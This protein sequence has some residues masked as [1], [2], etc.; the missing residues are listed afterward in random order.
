MTENGNHTTYLN[1]DFWGDG[2]WH[3][4]TLQKITGPRA[5]ESPNPHVV[6]LLDSLMSDAH[7]GAE[8]EGNKSQGFD[9]FR[10]FDCNIIVYIIYSIYIIYIA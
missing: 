9:Q 4:F 7:L 3:C 2:L 1:G 5:R 10:N 6:Q 8:L